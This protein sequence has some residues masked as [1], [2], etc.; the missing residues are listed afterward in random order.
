MPSRRPSK[1]QQ[2]KKKA[3]LKRRSISDDEFRIASENSDNMNVQLAVCRR[4]FGV[5]SAEDLRACSLHALWR[6]LQYHDPKYGQKFTTSLHRFTAWEIQREL[7]KQK[8]SKAQQN[9]AMVPLY[10][11]E[12]ELAKEENV[13][14]KDMVDHIRQRATLLPYAW[15][16]KVVDQYYFQHLTMEQIGRRNGYSKESARQKVRKAMAELRQLCQPGLI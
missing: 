1:I 14:R 8:G 16:R 6:C 7:R 5:M 4:Y 12:G 13:S 10:G 3:P 9:M 15:Q 11:T 2:Q